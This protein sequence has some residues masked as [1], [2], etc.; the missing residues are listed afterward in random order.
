MKK[1]ILI[2]AIA[3]GVI[4]CNDDNIIIDNNDVVTGLQLKTNFVSK[5]KK[6][7][8]VKFELLGNSEITSVTINISFDG[9][10]KVNGNPVQ[11]N[12][13]YNKNDEVALI[14]NQFGRTTATI[15]LPKENNSRNYDFYTVDSS[16]QEAFIYVNNLIY[17]SPQHSNGKIFYE[18]V[19][20]SSSSYSV[21]KVEIVVLSAQN[22]SFNIIEDKPI[23]NETNLNFSGNE[24]LNKFEVGLL[25][26]NF[27]TNNFRFDFD[28]GQ[29]F[30]MP[31]T[32]IRTYQ[33]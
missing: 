12:F 20:S 19:E 4:S 2:I 3:F 10:V 11:G 28:S 14:P 21:N 1:F 9:T 27:G 23:L 24:L 16:S 5:D 15:S 26:Q 31:F 25:E 6:E 32:Y 33:K 30:N 22:F 29:V 7:I 17:R 8:P 13:I 18:T